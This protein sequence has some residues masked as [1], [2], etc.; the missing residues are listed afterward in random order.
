MSRDVVLDVAEFIPLEFF[1]SKLL[2]R[3]IGDN[4]TIWLVVIAAILG[5]SISLVIEILQY[6]W[7][8]SRYSSAF[9]LVFNSLGSII[10]VFCNRFLGCYRQDV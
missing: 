3:K 7:V 8:V 4:E 10:G 2:N 6:L 5:F 1:V 9:D